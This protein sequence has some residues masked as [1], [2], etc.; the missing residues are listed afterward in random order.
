MLVN[1]IYKLVLTLSIC[2]QLSLFFIMVAVALWIDRL[3]NSVI[4]DFARMQTLYKATSITTLVV[5]LPS[6]LGQM[7]NI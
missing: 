2:L 5:S 4:G 6:W 1:H 7:K 3:V